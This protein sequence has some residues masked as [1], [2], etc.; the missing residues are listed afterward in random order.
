LL[1]IK[2]WP[3]ILLLMPHCRAEEI[4]MSYKTILAILQG[5][6]DAARVLGCAVP[7]AIST[8]RI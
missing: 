4:A 1:S 6:D 2:D 3:W 7:L 5:K 8:A